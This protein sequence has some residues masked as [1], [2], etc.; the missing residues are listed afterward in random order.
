MV[1]GGA[2]DL[3]EM[4]DL[5][6]RGKSGTGGSSSARHTSTCGDVKAQ[7]NGKTRPISV[8]FWSAL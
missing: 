8:F 4:T 5:S 7:G 6:E 2:A 1:I 3:A